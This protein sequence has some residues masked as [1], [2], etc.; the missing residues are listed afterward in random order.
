MIGIQSKQKSIENI[1]LIL[2]FGA[3]SF[4]V[5][6]DDGFF[7]HSADVYSEKHNHSSFEIQLIKKGEGILYIGQT[8][9][10]L[11]VGNFA[12]IGGGIYHSIYSKSPDFERIDFRLHL[13]QHKEIN[14]DINSDIQII[15]DVFSKDFTYKIIPESLILS[16]LIDEITCEMNN[17]SLCFF[18]IIKHLFS[19]VIINI[20]REISQK[21]KVENDIPQKVIDEKRS[22]LIEKFFDN[23]DMNLLAGDLANLLNVSKRQL[24]RIM[25]DT[26]HTTFK[27]K[28]LDT[29]IEVAKELLENS[30]MKISEIAERVG[31]MSEKGFSNMFKKKTSFTP[32]SY[33]LKAKHD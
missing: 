27:Q 29:R 19:M 13:K 9:V 8:K 3:I 1:K 26:Y 5:E 14:V 30:D 32:S 28:L 20:V 23:Y 31:Y 18:S 21:E 12:F 22:L 25:L 7:G 33:R 2:E 24:N 6:L 11:H 10:P 4:D 16:N 17:K 15:S